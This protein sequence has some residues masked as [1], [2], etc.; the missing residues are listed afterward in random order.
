MEYKDKIKEIDEYFDKIT[1]QELDNLVTKYTNEDD[2]DKTPLYLDYLKKITKIFTKGL[3]MV[4]AISI[5]CSLAFLL[6]LPLVMPLIKCALIY[7]IV[8]FIISVFILGGIFDYD[9]RY[10]LEALI[11]EYQ[12]YLES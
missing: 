6:I 1:P 4:V 7:K 12:D 10:Q 2:Y 3:S 8:S 11:E 5:G 9:T